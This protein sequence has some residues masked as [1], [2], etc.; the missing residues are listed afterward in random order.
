MIVSPGQETRQIQWEH[1]WRAWSSRVSAGL[2][3]LSSAKITTDTLD[4]ISGKRLSSGSLKRPK[5]DIVVIRRDGT[6]FGLIMEG[7]TGTLDDSDVA[8]M[9]AGFH[10]VD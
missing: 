1:E 10:L 9:K 3:L 2:S 6:F 7:L 4:G 8:A 5:E